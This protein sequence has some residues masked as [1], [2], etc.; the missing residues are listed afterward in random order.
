MASYCYP[1][2][3]RSGLG[4]LLLVWA[5]AAVFGHINHLPMLGPRWGMIRLGPLFRAESRRRLYYGYFKGSGIV[6]S[7]KRSAVLR[8][9]QRIVDPPIGPLSRQDMA[10]SNRVYVF[11]KS[12][13]WA[14]YFDGIREHRDFVR[15]ALQEM[16]AARHRQQLE[17][18]S[19]PVVGVHVR[20]GDFREL[21]PGEDFTQTGGV[22][23]PLAYFQYVMNMIRKIA[24]ATLPVTLFSDGDDSELRELLRMPDVARSRNHSDIVDLLLLARSQIIVSSPGSTFSYWSGFLSD[25]PVI[26]ER[27]HVHACT[28]P[29][30]VNQS[31][32]EGGVSCSD[33]R[34]P[35]FLEDNIRT[36]AR[37]MSGWPS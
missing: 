33:Q 10:A 12:P 13:H 29:A 21:R 5:R 28:R 4:N 31:V 23:A 3:P 19:P 7:L 16:L 6:G 32:F 8:S 20:R 18:A 36:T 17:R 37:L 9:H 24:G 14:D 27:S 35:A 26:H 30:A 15:D 11:R 1:D 34:W 22:R 25:A 2:L